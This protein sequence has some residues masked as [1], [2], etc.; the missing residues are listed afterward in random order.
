MPYLARICVYPIK[1]LAPVSPPQALVL[2]GGALEHDRE[3]AFF[4]EDG[5]FLNGKRSA[6]IHGLRSVFDL[7]A[8]ALCLEAAETGCAGRFRLP[9]DIPALEA[10]G[11]A[12]FGQPV[13]FRQNAQSGFPDDLNASGPTVISTATLDLVA[14]W[15]P[16][17]SVES[18]RVRFRANLEI[19][20]VPPFWE[21]R[22][23]GEP[24]TLTPFQIG[25]V[26]FHGVNPCQR[27]VVPPRDPETGEMTAD[28]SAVFRAKREETLPPWAARTRFNHFYRLAVNTRVPESEAGKRLHV[29]AAVGA[30]EAQ[31]LIPAR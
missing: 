17:L 14:S 4:T 11:S 21:D 24:D 16:G 7:D 28:F 19:G 22:L 23:F 10:W 12:Y 13:F 3:W 25:D 15:F 30:A 27:C 5:K 1:S 18:A 6:K 26:Q 9:D 20:G 8:G 31:Q 29:G 2:A